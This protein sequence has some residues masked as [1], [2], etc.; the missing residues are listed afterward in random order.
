MRRSVPSL[1]VST[2]VAG[3]ALLSSVKRVGTACWSRFSCETSACTVS[4]TGAPRASSCRLDSM[5]AL[6][7]PW[8][9]S[10]CR[11]SIWL[12]CVSWL[13]NSLESVGDS[14]SWLRI[15]ATSKVVNRFET[16]P[17]PLIAA[18]AAAVELLLVVSI[19]VLI[20]VLSQAQQRL[21]HRFHAP[22]HLDIGLEGARGG[23]HVGHL[24]NRVD[25]GVE[26]LAVLVGQRVLGLVDLAQ[27]LVALDAG[28]HLHAAAGQLVLAE[29]LAGGERGEHR[30][31]RT[32]GL[33]LAAGGR[34]R[35]RQVAGDR[36]QP[37][38]LGRHR[39]AG[40]LADLL[41]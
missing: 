18:L 35:I 3:L 9:A 29:A 31:A 2:R 20:S 7:A 15:C 25:V 10:C 23:Q 1:E 38:G 34:L 6:A 21:L 11:V 36:V 40:D 14:G 33:G 24:G 39:R 5:L 17:L 30:L 4:P 22:Q 27:R 28:E 16:L 32:V 26:H 8:L 41:E 12:I 37:R 19:V 13:T